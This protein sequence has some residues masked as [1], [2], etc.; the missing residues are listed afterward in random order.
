MKLDQHILVLPL[1]VSEKALQFDPDNE[2]AYVAKGE[3]LSEP[4]RY[5]E[6]LA[7]FK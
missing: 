3:S 2:L 1:M 6:A 7:A 5:E 4:G